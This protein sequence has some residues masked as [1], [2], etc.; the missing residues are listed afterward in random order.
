VA[1]SF[2][3]INFLTIELVAIALVIATNS[4]FNKN[5]LVK[6][7]WQ[8]PN[9]VLTGDLGRQKIITNF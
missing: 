6:R 7:G 3:L 5:L 4:T 8:H 9:W 2:L 1:T